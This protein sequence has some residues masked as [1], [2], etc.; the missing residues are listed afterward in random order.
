[1]Y[2]AITKECNLKS[3]DI[4]LFK[5]IIYLSAIIFTTWLIEVEFGIKRLYA[6]P[7][8][9]IIYTTL[10]IVCKKR[11]KVWIMLCQLYYDYILNM[12]YCLEPESYEITLKLIDSLKGIA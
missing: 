11:K 1:M 6:M 12:C 9:F 10:L 8:V 3:E 4:N 5:F 7:V 2:I